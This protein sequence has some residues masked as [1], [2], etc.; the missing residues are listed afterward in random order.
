MRRL[1]AG[2]AA[3]LFAVAAMATIPAA[4]AGAFPY[5]HLDIAGHG[6][7][8]GRGMGQFGALG[9]ALKGTSYTD[10]L[11]H[12]Y[13]NTTAGGIGNDLVTVQLVANDGL[14]AIVM[15]EHG[16]LTTDAGAPTPGNQAVRVRKIGPN[17]FAVDQAPNCNGPWQLGAISAAHPGTVTISP[18]APSAAHDSMLQVCYIGSSRWYEGDILAVDGDG[19]ARTINRLPMESYLRGVVPRE[20]PASW[21]QLGGGA[22]EEALK[23][24]AVAARSY[25]KAENRQ[26]WAQTGDTTSCQVYGGRAVQDGG[27]YQDLYG[28]GVYAT[29]SDVAVSSTGGQVRMLNGGVARAESSSSTGGSTAGGVFPAVVDEGDDVCAN[30]AACNSNHNWTANV[31]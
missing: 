13:S 15:Q 11:S 18:T 8:H 3:S 26:P 14:D 12:F 19:P 29:T 1:L 31:P 5:D 16:N 2:A 21:G 27:G 17:Q 25:A 20:S 10:I 23:A 6:F 4:P 22:G 7:G 28:A 9:Y 30:A 24:Q